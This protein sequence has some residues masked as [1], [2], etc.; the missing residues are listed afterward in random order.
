MK[1]IPLS[2]FPPPQFIL[3]PNL[4]L[5]QNIFQSIFK[6]PNR[7]ISIPLFPP[8]FHHHFHWRENPSPPS[9]YRTLF[10]LQNCSSVSIVLPTGSIQ[11]TISSKQK[12]KK[13]WRRNRKIEHLNRFIKGWLSL[14]YFSF[15]ITLIHTR[16]KV[17]GEVKTHSKPKP[18]TA[19]LSVQQETGPVHRHDPPQQC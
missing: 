14:V 18:A 12:L 6:G 5:S 2:L 10:I 11:F 13:V 15:C 7:P 16:R 9:I 4:A 19:L 1:E 3:L 17:I 8:L